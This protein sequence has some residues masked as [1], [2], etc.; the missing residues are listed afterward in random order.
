MAAAV[1]GRGRSAGGGG[2][3]RA[4]PW[5]T[6][7]GRP[8]PGS[9]RSG[10]TAGCGIGSAGSPGSKFL[11]RAFD[12]SRAVRAQVQPLVQ[13][14]IAVE[15]HDDLVLAGLDVEALERPVVIF[16]LAG[17]ITVDVDRSV[18]RL[19]FDP[20]V[21]FGKPIPIGRVR[22]DR[23]IAKLGA[24]RGGQANRSQRQDQSGNAS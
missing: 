18:F 3:R 15:V 6:I 16:D 23:R 21:S 14:S 7:G 11:E 24:S 17:K 1:A 9:C 4:P 5:P 19:H 13:A 10:W 2:G 22:I 8:A 20:Q 12:F